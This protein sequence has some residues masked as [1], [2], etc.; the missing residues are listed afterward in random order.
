MGTHAISRPYPGQNP[1]RIHGQ[2][3]SGIQADFPGGFQWNVPFRFR[4]ESEW[5][6]PLE[7]AGEVRLYSAWILSMDSHR[8]LTGIRT[9]NGMGSHSF[10]IFIPWDSGWFPLL[11]QSFSCVF[12]FD[13]KT[14]ILVIPQSTSS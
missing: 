8:I 12:L 2:N 6:I 11:F 14:L 3:P 7:S 4:P 1:V 10:S 5:D 13:S 9:G